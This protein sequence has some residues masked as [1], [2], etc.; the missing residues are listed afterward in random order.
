MFK[1][2]IRTPPALRLTIAVY[3]CF[4]A[5][6]CSGEASFLAGEWHV[7]LEKTLAEYA[8]PQDLKLGDKL[9][10]AAL[11]QGS[12]ALVV[13]F[14]RSN[15]V[16]II[17]GKKSIRRTFDVVKAKGTTVA[18]SIKTGPKQYRRVIASLADDQLALVDSHQRIVLSRR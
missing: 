12:T 16:H 18:L 11:R 3:I 5:L 13:R 1:R 8:A 2:L 15:T 14:E 10:V 9:D 6:G 17:H 7:D 4:G